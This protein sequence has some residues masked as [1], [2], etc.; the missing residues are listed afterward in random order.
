M[1]VGDAFFHQPC[2]FVSL[3]IV[4]HG[5]S[6]ADAEIKVPSAKSLQLSSVSY[7]VQS[8]RV[9]P[10]WSRAVECFLC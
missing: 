4:I 1:P 7:L 9:F 2:S 6:T 8:C 5:Q 3:E 10:I